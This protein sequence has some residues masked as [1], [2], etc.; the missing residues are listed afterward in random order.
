VGINP[1][2]TTEQQVWLLEVLEHAR[3]GHLNRLQSW[4]L[5]F[6]DSEQ[7]PVRALESAREAQ[8]CQ[9][10]QAALRRALA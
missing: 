8:K 10:V 7:A 5:E 3:Q 4:T 6:A 1:S 2:L 9:D